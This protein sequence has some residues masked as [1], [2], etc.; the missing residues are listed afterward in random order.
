MTGH[1]LD[2]GQIH[3]G[4]EQVAGPGPTRARAAGAWTV[5][6]VEEESCALRSAGGTSSHGCCSSP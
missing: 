5:E 2:R 1:L 6:L 3:P 4:L